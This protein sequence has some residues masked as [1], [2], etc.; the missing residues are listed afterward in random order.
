MF[1]IPF[2]L[3]RL[4]RVVVHVYRL[5]YFLVAVQIYSSSKERSTSKNDKNFTP[6]AAGPQRFYIEKR[7]RSRIVDSEFFK[8]WERGRAPLFPR[9]RD[10]DGA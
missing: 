6:V 7:A 3:S 4:M 9:F 10:E 1:P 8:L 2:A 5:V